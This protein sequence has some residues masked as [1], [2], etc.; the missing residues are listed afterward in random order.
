MAIME[1]VK[2][3]EALRA[4]NEKKQLQIEKYEDV[5]EKIK[6]NFDELRFAMLEQN[7]GIVGVSMA[8]LEYI[9]KNEL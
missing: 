7:A 9:L 3:Y 8:R 1:T 2:T 4:E 5:I 6:K